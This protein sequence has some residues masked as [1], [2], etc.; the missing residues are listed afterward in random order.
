MFICKFMK[1]LEMEGFELIEVVM[2]DIFLHINSRK[3]GSH[4]KGAIELQDKEHFHRVGALCNINCSLLNLLVG[5]SL[6]MEA[7]NSGDLLL[8]SGI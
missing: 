5:R 1:R 6:G 3:I 8:G 2:P 4:V 7:N